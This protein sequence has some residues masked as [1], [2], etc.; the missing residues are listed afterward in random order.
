M[1]PAKKSA[2]PKPTPEQDAFRLAVLDKTSTSSIILEA[3]AGSGKTTSIVSPLHELYK[4]TKKKFALIAFNRSIA[5]EL[6]ARLTDLEIPQDRGLAGT[7]HSFGLAAYKKLDI[8]W[9]KVDGKKMV[10]LTDQY[11]NEQFR[12]PAEMN[13]MCRKLVSLAKQAGAGIDELGFSIDNDEKWMELVYQHDV[14]QTEG[15]DPFEVVKHARTLLLRSIR[16]LNI[17]D[18]DDMIYMPLL[19]NVTF[20]QYD[21]VM[22]DEAQDTNPVRR[23]MAMRMLRTVDGSLNGKVIGRLCAVGDRRQAIY[24]FTGAD[25]DSLDRI[26]EA[27]NAVE[28]PLTVCFRCDRKIVEFAQQWNPVIRP[29]SGAKDGEVSSMTAAEFIEKNG[30]TNKDVM[31]CRNTKPLIEMAFALIR[32]GTAVYVEG[33]DIGEGLKALAGRWKVKNLEVL[34]DRLNAWKER[35]LTK[36][37]EKKNDG[38]KQYIED[39]YD[40]LMVFVNICR[41]KNLTTVNDVMNEINYIFRDTKEG[42]RPDCFTLSTIH[43]S[44]GRE[45]ETVYWLDRVGTLP[46]KYAKQAWQIGQENNLCYVAATRAKHRLVEVVK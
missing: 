28:M 24:G 30:V 36:A 37:E 39:Q 33:R 25:A 43:K 9:V 35:E 27:T 15:I 19:K 20:D 42:E 6:A 12:L 18:F 14:V 5:N 17:I 13:G 41:S 21:F 2:A 23:L 10:N 31:L 32:K 16:Q 3:V 29:F 4:T 40:T 34:V 38:R 8:K 7:C 44:K 46:S 22:L 1:S 26:R 11:F 45:W